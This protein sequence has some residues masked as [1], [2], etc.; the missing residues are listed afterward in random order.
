M[1]QFHPKVE[2][3]SFSL[4]EFAVFCPAEGTAQEMV[5]VAISV[6]RQNGFGIDHYK[7][8]DDDPRLHIEYARPVNGQVSYVWHGCHVHSESD[9]PSSPRSEGASVGDGRNAGGASDGHFSIANRRL[10][11]YVQW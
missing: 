2:D 5:G 11:D 6:D 9:S 8:P 4:I 10:V 7:L 3:N 1:N